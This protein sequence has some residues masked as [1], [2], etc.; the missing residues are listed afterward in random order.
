MPVNPSTLKSRY[1]KDHYPVYK[2]F[3]T[4]FVSGV[5]GLRHFD[6]NKCLQYFGNYIT[7]SDEAFTVL[8]LENNWERWSDMAESDEW[9]E[10]SVPSKWTTS[11]EKRASN[12]QPDKVSSDTSVVTPQARRF[13]GWTAQGINRYNQLFM[14]IKMER[15][16]KTY[17]LI[18]EYCLGEYQSDAEANGN[19]SHKRKKVDADKALPIAIHE[20]WDEKKSPEEESDEGI[21]KR[22]PAYFGGG[23]GV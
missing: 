16:K 9:R 8:T 1:E 7:V 5:V 18:E 17:R 19:N 15:A 13:R 23:H 12:Q 10:S 11:T 14:E 22:M 21:V 2:D 20:L 4:F 6:R 3:L